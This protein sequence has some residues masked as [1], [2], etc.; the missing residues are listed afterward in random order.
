M[1]G[2]VFAVIDRSGSMGDCVADTINGFNGF[3]G[4]LRDQAYELKLTT[5]LFDNQYELLH[6]SVPIEKVVPLTA[7]DYY[8]RGRTA[9]MDAIGRT[10]SES[11]KRIMMTPE[12][13]KPQR[14]IFLIITDGKENASIEYN[15]NQVRNMIEDRKR[16]G[17]EFVFLGAGLEDMEDAEQIGI[18]K[19]HRTSFD[20]K[21]TE[22]IYFRYGE[23][24]SEYMKSENIQDGFNTK[25]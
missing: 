14:I 15:A 20:K 9:L 17:W 19:A 10:I 6:T 23:A 8:V 18:D 12:S 24:V 4:K 21:N 2:E 7:H 3:I 16:S 11:I 13:E 5:V 25:K 22:N 1:R